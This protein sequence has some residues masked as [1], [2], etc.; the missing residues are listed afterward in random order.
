MRSKPVIA[1]DGPSGVGKTTVAKGVADALGFVFVDT[2]ALYRTMA[3]VAFRSN[4]DL[5]AEEAVA[6]LATTHRFK[7]RKDGFLY[8]DGHRVGDEI[9]TPKMS[10]GASAVAKHPSV[11]AA[12]L[13]IQRAQGRN[14]GVV[15][16]GRDVGTAVFPDAE[17]K[18]FLTA[19]KEERA[20]RRY[21]ELKKRGNKIAFEDVLE[22]Q[23]RRD[24]ADRNRSAAPLVKADDAVLVE[25][26]DMSVDE[27]IASILHITRT[28]FPLTSI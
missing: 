28:N 24:E 5:E 17:V 27:V 11:R 3:Y 7:Y 26:D 2:G 25:C 16:E 20:K 18:I 10:M 23:E 4:V 9:R 8:L 6:A 21:L 14:G 19:R 1:I 22:D 13:G 12:L 15:L